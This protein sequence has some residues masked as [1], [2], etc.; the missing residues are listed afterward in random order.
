MENKQGR[1]R[2]NRRGQTKQRDKGETN[3]TH[4]QGI[5]VSKQGQ[6]TYNDYTLEN[7][8]YTHM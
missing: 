6:K 7:Y 2:Q 5:Q 1:N 8:G 4:L 3:G